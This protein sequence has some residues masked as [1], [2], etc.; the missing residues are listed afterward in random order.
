[1]GKRKKRPP[2]AFPPLSQGCEV[3]TC[4]ITTTTREESL[5]FSAPLLISFPIL[6]IS[7]PFDSLENGTQSEA[8][9][10]IP[11]RLEFLR[12]FSFLFFFF[13]PFET[14]SGRRREKGQGL[15]GKEAWRMICNS[16]IK[17]QNSTRSEF[18]LIPLFFCHSC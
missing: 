1:M 12:I 6:G 16:N 11:S 18:V 14:R 4:V 5:L 2:L 3:M 13:S 15:S 10:V 9:C 17:C 8:A 7:Q